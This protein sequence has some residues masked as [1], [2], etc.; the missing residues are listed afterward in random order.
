MLKITAQELTNLQLILPTDKRNPS[1]T[2]YT[3]GLRIKIMENRTENAFP[4]GGV[5]RGQ[6]S[7]RAD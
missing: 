4:E 1:F 7:F 2:I 6:L 5:H 3:Q